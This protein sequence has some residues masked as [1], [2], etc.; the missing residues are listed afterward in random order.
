[1]WGQEKAIKKNYNYSSQIN[2]FGQKE[3]STADVFS[4]DILTIAM[5]S[6]T[7]F[8]EDYWCWVDEYMELGMIFVLS[9]L[10]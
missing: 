1:M 7:P 10:M 9:Q 5:E 8:P 2:Y 4:S 3:T 6:I